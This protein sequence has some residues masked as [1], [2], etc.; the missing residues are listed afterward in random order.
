MTAGGIKETPFLC[1]DLTYISVLLQELDFPPDKELKVCY[2]WFIIPDL[3]ELWNSYFVVTFGHLLQHMTCICSVTA[4]C[5][6]SVIFWWK[7]V[8]DDP[9]IYFNCIILFKFQLARQINNVETSWALGATFQYI[10]SLRKHGT[11]WKH[12]HSQR[13]Y[14]STTQ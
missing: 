9:V 7:N 14:R 6:L 13:L 1:L 5:D 8:M 4:V 12:R 3:I 2:S 11:C 10:E